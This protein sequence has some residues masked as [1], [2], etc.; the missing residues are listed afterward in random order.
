M[1]AQAEYEKAGRPMEHEMAFGDPLTAPDVLNP[2]LT[3]TERVVR[4]VL[5]AGFLAVLVLEA[6]LIWR[7][8]PALF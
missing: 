7:A 2:G 3:A 6:W 8:W 5:L 4:G 1:E